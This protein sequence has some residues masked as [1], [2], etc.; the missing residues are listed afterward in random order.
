MNSYARGY[1]K[2]LED[3]ELDHPPGIVEHEIQSRRE[4][5][6]NQMEEN[7]L[8]NARLRIE[9]KYRLIRENGHRLPAKHLKQPIQKS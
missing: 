6:L 9:R 7:E 3:I 1:L 8:R 4:A 5:F 2:A